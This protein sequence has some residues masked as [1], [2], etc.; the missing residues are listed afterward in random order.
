MANE[1]MKEIKTRIALK[2][3]TYEYWTTGEGKDYAPLKGEVCFCAIESK[4]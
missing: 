2:Y 1:I 3:N 4:D